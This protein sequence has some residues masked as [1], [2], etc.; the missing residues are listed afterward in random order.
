MNEEPP[1]LR[2]LLF[3]VNVD[4]TRGDFSPRDSLGKQPSHIAGTTGVRLTNNLV[5]AF[6]LVPESIDGPVV[7]CVRLLKLLQ[8]T[9][10][11]GCVELQKWTTHRPIPTTLTLWMRDG[12]LN[13]QREG[14]DV[15]SMYVKPEVFQAVRDELLYP[16]P[17]V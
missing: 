15:L 8:P 12:R 1:V 10:D 4:V 6:D 2:E 11:G 9:P 5:L 17:E 3:M 13:M 7:G 16:V 14:K